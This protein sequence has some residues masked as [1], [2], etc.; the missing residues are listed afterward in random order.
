MHIPHDP[1][2]YEKFYFTQG[3]LG[4]I[5][6]KTQNIVIS[7]L[8]CYD[9]W[10]PEAARINTLNG[11]QMIFYPT[12]IGYFPALLQAEPFSAQRW[13]NAMRSHAS[14]NG[15]FTAGVNRVGKEADIIFWGGSFI[16]DPFGEIVAR[17]S[18]TDEEA[19]VAEIDLSKIA[20]CQEG[21]GFLRNR[22]PDSYGDLV[23]P[24]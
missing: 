7:P 4:Y 10:F 12:A 8:I 9:Q 14:L 1:L 19:L 13:E 15:I 20:E 24:I 2:Y 17:A 11:T 6:V 18:A 23:K 3:N 16:A 22:R 21:W 5:Q